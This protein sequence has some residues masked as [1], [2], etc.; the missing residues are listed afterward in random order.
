MPS[1]G[2]SSLDLGRT[3]IPPAHFSVRVPVTAFGSYPGLPH[4]N[5]NWQSAV[6]LAG[7]VVRNRR[8]HPHF[9][10]L[11]PSYSDFAFLQC[12]AGSIFLLPIA[13]LHTRFCIAE[14]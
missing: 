12:M 3:G 4:R 6:R 5:T 14:R 9:A 11:N 1:L 8:H 13:A 7:S 10:Y 2:V